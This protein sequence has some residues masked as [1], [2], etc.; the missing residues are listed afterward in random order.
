MIKIIFLAILII[1]NITL[2]Q[3]PKRNTQYNPE[4]I[5]LQNQAMEMLFNN[6]INRAEYIDSALVMLEKAYQLDSTFYH[7]LILKIG[8]YTEKEDYNSAIETTHKVLNNNPDHAELIMSLGMFYD[9]IDK[10]NL[11]TKYYKSAI[12]IFKK[13]VQYGKFSEAYNQ[14]H[15]GLCLVFLGEENKGKALILKHENN[16]ETKFTIQ[17]LKETGFKK[18]YWINQIFNK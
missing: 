7:A 14:M 1:S 15:I 3:E 18:E 4:S 6:L 12:D 10:N 13:R 17:I 11:A 9:F 5:E 16:P 8:L 2:S